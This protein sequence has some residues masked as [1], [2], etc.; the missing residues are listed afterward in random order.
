MPILKNKIVWKSIEALH[1]EAIGT[2]PNTSND[3]R[4]IESGPTAVLNEGSVV[5]QTLQTSGDDV[6]ARI[7]KLL[8]KL[9]E[10]ENSV[11]FFEEN[12]Q[13]NYVANDAKKVDQ[14]YETAPV[15][16]TE[17]VTNNVS[18]ANPASTEQDSALIGIAAAIHEAQQNSAKAP[19]ETSDSDT[20]P[21]F[22][23]AVLSTT[24][25]DEVRRAISLVIAS[26]MPRV[27]RQAVSDVIHESTAS[28]PKPTPTK[29]MR[30]KRS[31]IKKP[32]TKK[33]ETKKPA[34]K[35]TQNKKTTAKKATYT[36]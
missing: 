22:D 30:A 31:A 17:A 29:K 5:E 1:D 11:T 26:E 18:L 2:M 8:E 28:E 19:T 7:D 27:V 16:S 4:V 25:A 13:N 6:T 24:I 32:E 33:P 35:K 3:I 10:N 14:S 21:Q 23:M 12:K 34:T 9:D 36:S 15:N 20:P